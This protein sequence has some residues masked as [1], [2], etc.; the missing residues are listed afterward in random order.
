MADF[1]LLES[2]KLI[3]RKIWVIEKSW[4]FH[5]VLVK[6]A[7]Y[8]VVLNVQAAVHDDVDDDGDFHGPTL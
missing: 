2:P 1:A 4:N 7:P 6:H 3:S 8:D 5:T